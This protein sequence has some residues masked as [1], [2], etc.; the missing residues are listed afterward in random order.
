MSRVVTCSHTHILY[1]CIISNQ[2]HKQLTC[3][4][5][6]H[7]VY[8]CIKR[9]LRNLCDQYFMMFL[10]HYILFHLA[11]LFIHACEHS[12]SL[13]KWQIWLAYRAFKLPL[14]PTVK[15]KTIGSFSQSNE[16][17]DYIVHSSFL[18]AKWPLCRLFKSSCHDSISVHFEIA[19]STWQN[20]FLCHITQYKP[21]SLYWYQDSE[22]T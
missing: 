5:P 4:K 9:Q 2:A 22:Y 12:I 21:K 7:Q 18:A 8:Q 1:C 20:N 16:I 13:I 11:R 3:T 10:H 19:R 15:S 17:M 14:H 6:F